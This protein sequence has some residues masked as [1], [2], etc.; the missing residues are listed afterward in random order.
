MNVTN[1]ESSIHHDD[2]L[3][4]VGRYFWKGDDKNHP[5]FS[6][7]GLEKFGR[8]PYY[9]APET[10]LKSWRSMQPWAEGAWSAAQRGAKPKK[11]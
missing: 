5:T 6:K 3:R 2:A 9:A 4:P 11:R 10:A 7:A 1:R 8:M